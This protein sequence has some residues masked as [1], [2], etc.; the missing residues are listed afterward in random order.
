MIKKSILLVG[1]LAVNSASAT[2]RFEKGD[3]TL[4]K[5][6]I[7]TNQY[8]YFI[9]KKYNIICYERTRGSGI[10]LSCISLDKRSK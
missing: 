4:Y 3:L 6:S 1:L 8:R 5:P 10:A 2:D 7:I 9:D